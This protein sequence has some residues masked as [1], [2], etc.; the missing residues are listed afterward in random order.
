M[1]DDGWYLRS[2]VIWH[3]PNA[4][5]SSVKKRPTTDHEYV[6]LM[7]PEKEYFYNANAIREPH[8]TFSEK[9]KMKGGRKHFGKRGGTPGTR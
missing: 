9:S 6:F 3:K 4:M 1:M 5:P 2:D 8:V 7:T